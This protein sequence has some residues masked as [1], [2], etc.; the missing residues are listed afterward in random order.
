MHGLLQGDHGPALVRILHTISHHS[1][2]SLS[3]AEHVCNHMRSSG[4]TAARTGACWQ[5][6]LRWTL[7]AW[8]RRSRCAAR[9]C[10]PAWRQC[11]RCCLRT[12]WP[13]A[14]TATSFRAAAAT[15]RALGRA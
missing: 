15:A 3:R 1:Y 8:R 14:A 12:L 10:W 13:S 6:M 7:A 5:R 4:R 11:C 2:V 9:S